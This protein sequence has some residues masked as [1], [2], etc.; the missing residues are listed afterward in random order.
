MSTASA[1]NLVPRAVSVGLAAGFL[2]GVFGVGGGILVVP[3]LVIVMKMDQRLAHG[4]SLATVLPIS[5][6]SLI[7]YGIGGE[8][9]WPVALFLAIG[10]VV[11][12]VVGTKLLHVLP[13][14][15]LAFAFSALLLATAVRLFIPTTSTGRDDLGVGVALALVIA[16]VITGILAGL[17]GVGGGI[18]MVPVMVVLLGLPPVLA[19]GTSVAVIVPTAIMGTWRNRTKRNADLR[20]AGIVG[21]AGITSAL[22][23]TV[24]SRELSDGLSNLLFALLLTVVA[25]KMLFEQFRRA[26]Q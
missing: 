7:G 15:V 18:V 2:S 10:A 14:R 26:A 12:A 3:A 16:G 25:V 21:V 19:K 17:L 24:V 22:L 8:V 5:V 20:V 11:G 9:D 13:P 6:A 4:T 1:S 23:G